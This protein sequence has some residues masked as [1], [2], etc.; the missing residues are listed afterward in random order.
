MC[1]IGTGV[2]HAFIPTTT[3]Q[4]MKMTSSQLPTNKGKSLALAFVSC[5]VLAL[6][7]TTHAATM[8]GAYWAFQ[9]N[10]TSTIF[11][12]TV[13]VENLQGT[14]T[15]SRTG[16]GTLGSFT[17]AG[18]QAYTNRIDE[19]LWDGGNTSAWNGHAT[20]TSGEFT[21]SDLNFTAIEVTELRFGYRVTNNATLHSASFSLEYNIGSGFVPSGL[22]LTPFTVNGSW[23]AYTIDLTSLDEIDEESN[24]ALRFTFPITESASHNV[25]ID[26]LEIV[27]I[28][29]P[30]SSLLLLSASALMLA[31]RRR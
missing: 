8:L 25:R 10:P 17:G 12:E 16:G 29:E 3:E 26:N 11:S 27:G 13:R 6:V 5:G 14:P 22:A 2:K 19:T 31:R 15:F 7:P 28:P 4:P 20:N 23:H 21:I 9:E 30:S 18:A 24:V 1:K